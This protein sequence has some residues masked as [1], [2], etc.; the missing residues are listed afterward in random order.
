MKKIVKIKHFS[1][2]KITHFSSDKSFKGFV[3]NWSRLSI[4]G[5]SLYI[6]KAV[7][8]CKLLADRVKKYNTVKPLV[9]NTSKEF[10]KCRILHF[11]IM[12]CWRYLVF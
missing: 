8:F 10:I 5:G 11:L 4:N 2:Q 9:T 7:H 3:V 12:E 6:E 1:G